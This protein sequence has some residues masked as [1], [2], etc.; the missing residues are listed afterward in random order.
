M[1]E[2]IRPKSFQYAEVQTQPPRFKSNPMYPKKAP[3]PNARGL[4]ADPKALTSLAKGPPPPKNRR[5]RYLGGISRT[6]THFWLVGTATKYFLAPLG[7]QAH[8]KDDSLVIAVHRLM[9][10]LMARISSPLPY[11]KIPILGRPGVWGGLGSGEAKIQEHPKRTQRVQGHL[12]EG[13]IALKV[14]N[15]Y[16]F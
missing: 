9:E 2:L 14:H 12:H 6:G 8:V 5:S 10:S 13:V 7:Q 3:D 15:Q 4:P 16:G 11:W 1:A